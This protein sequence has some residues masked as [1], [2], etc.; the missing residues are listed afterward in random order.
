HT[1]DEALL[2]CR[3]LVEAGKTFL[4]E[5]RLIGQEFSLMGFCDGKKI[6]HMPI[7]QDH[8]RAFENDVGPNTGGMGSYS[9]HDHSLPFLDQTDMRTAQK[10]N[11]AVLQ[12]LMQETGESYIGIL[13]GSFIATRDGVF[14][15]EFNARF[16]DPESLNVL[17]ILESDFVTL[18][19]AMCRGSLSEE[20]V[21]FARKATVCKYIVPVGY[22][23][24]VVRPEPVNFGF[25]TDP[26]HLYFGSIELC[27][28]ELYTMSSRTA[29]YV[30]VADVITAAE[31]LAELEIDRIEGPVLHRKDIG[32]ADAIDR[33]IAFMKQLRSNANAG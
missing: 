22:P 20:H 14:V 26:S 29:A 13:Y 12:A 3:S 19:E 5:Q 10:I 21:R 23:D 4:I 17:T 8:K 15:I 24:S 7:V 1:I 31:R 18:C 9:D 33:R 27:D 32:T 28:G 30:G 2:F 11:D 16:G 25:L 6:I